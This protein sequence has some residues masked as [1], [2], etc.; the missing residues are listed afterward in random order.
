M[1]LR[2]FIPEEAIKILWEQEMALG[3][4][5]NSISVATKEIRG[6][7]CNEWALVY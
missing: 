4:K 2:E 5:I 7:I 1:E 6:P 3:C